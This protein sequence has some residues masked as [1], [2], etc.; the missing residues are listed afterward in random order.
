MHDIG[1]QLGLKGND[2]LLFTH[3]AYVTL[4]RPY[5][6]QS[7]R[8]IAKKAGCGDES[9]VSRGIE[10]L[11]KKNV[12]ERS[13]EGL[14]VPQQLLAKYDAECNENLQNASPNM[15]NAN[16][17]KERSKE[18]NNIT[19]KRKESNKEN[20]PSIPTDF[21][22][23]WKTYD[24]TSEYKKLKN[25][26]LREWQDPDKMPQDW[27]QLAQKHAGQHPAERNPLFW[28][29]DQDFLK[30]EDTQAEAE[31]ARP[32]FIASQQIAMEMMQNDGVK[33]CIMFDPESST[34]RP[35]EYEKAK[36]FDGKRGYKIKM[37]W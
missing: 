20:I 27:K 19:N 30:Y 26:C 13:E 23:W 35:I 36:A 1:V 15:Q 33:I 11:V 31:T 5:C 9:T 16:N 6:T 7:N 14:C 8:L 32:P 37:V 28:L 17:Q 3:V 2:L 29:R 12:L 22:K 18:K 24:C 4:L 34:F 25:A 21:D 10:R